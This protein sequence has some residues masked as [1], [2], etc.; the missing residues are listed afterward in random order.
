MVTTDNVNVME[1]LENTFLIT[2][3]QSENYKLRFRYE[4]GC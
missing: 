4:K 3:L 1:K 2:S